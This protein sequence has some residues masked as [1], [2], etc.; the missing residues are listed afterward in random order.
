MAKRKR[1]REQLR[2]RQATPNIDGYGRHYFEGRRFGFGY[3]QK[4]DDREWQATGSYS[5]KNFETLKE[6]KAHVEK[7]VRH[8]LMRASRG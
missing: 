6:A 1:I 4:F 7:E 8:F 3:V 2:W 5:T